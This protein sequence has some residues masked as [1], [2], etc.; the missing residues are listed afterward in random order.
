MVN[1]Q[2]HPAWLDPDQGDTGNQLPDPSTIGYTVR[3]VAELIVTNS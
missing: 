1:E 3:R 2:M